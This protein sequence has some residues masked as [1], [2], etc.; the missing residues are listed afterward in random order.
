MVAVR[1]VVRGAARA[2]VRNPHYND[3][4]YRAHVSR[5]RWVDAPGQVTAMIRIERP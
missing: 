2:P 4:N 5:P 1:L 3:S